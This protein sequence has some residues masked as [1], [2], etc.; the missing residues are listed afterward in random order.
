MFDTINVLDCK[1]TSAS[2]NKPKYFG[3][4]D[5]SIRI[6]ALALCMERFERYLEKVDG[7]GVVIYERFGRGMSKKARYEARSLVG[8]FERID[9]KII[10]GDPVKRPILAYADF[11]AYAIQHKVM[12]GGTKQKRWNQIKERYIEGGYIE[13]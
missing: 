12:S 5:K 10:N 4:S 11:I 6:H 2:I 13:E 8:M 9:G 1:I 3:R 7:T